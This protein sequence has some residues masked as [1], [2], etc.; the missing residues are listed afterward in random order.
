M[1][2]SKGVVV[3]LVLFALYMMYFLFR[4][5]MSGSESVPDKYY[6]KGN[7]YQQELNNRDEAVRMGMKPVISYSSGTEEFVVAFDSM[8]ADSGMLVLQWPP[9][10]KQN[11]QSEMTSF[12]SKPLRVK[13]SSA[14]DGFWNAELI[15]YK[16]GLKFRYVQKVWTE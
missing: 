8:Y 15:Y 1:S 2:W 7:A 16:N 9:A 6:E 12:D 13:K 11:F 5:I 4:A 10:E 3:A 14:I